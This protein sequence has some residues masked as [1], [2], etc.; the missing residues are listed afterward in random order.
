M[1]PGRQE[2]I[3][4]DYGVKELRLFQDSPI[5]VTLQER[6]KIVA[7]IG[8]QTLTVAV[9][10]DEQVLYAMLAEQPGPPLDRLRPAFRETVDVDRQIDRVI[11][12]R[13]VN[14]SNGTT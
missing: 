3:L 7:A 14:L 13:V 2:S 4:L 6:K 9:G 10:S 8:E 5:S 12:E 1:I 11:A